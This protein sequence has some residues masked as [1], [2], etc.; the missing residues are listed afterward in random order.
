MAWMH[1]SPRRA[2]LLPGR[3]PLPCLQSDVAAGL[4]VGAMVIPQGMS[5]AKLAGLPQGAPPRQ[6]EATAG[7]SGA[8]AAVALPWPCRCTVV[9]HTLT[10]ALLPFTPAPSITTPA[11]PSLPPDP[12]YGLYGAFVPCIAYALLGSSRQ[13]VRCAAAPPGAACRAACRGRRWPAHLHPSP[14]GGGPCG[15]HLNYPRQRP[16][17]SV[18][19]AGGRGG[20]VGGWSVGAV[21][22]L[23]CSSGRRLLRSRG[24]PALPAAPSP[25]PLPPLRSCLPMLRTPTSRPSRS[26]SS[27]TTTLRCRWPLWRG[28]CTRAS[29]C[30]AWV[31]AAQGAPAHAAPAQRWIGCGAMS[32]GWGHGPP[33]RRGSPPLLRRPPACPPP[34]RLGHQL[35]VARPGVGLHDGRRNPHRPLPGAANKLCSTAA[36]RAAVVVALRAVRLQLRRPPGCRPPVMPLHCRVW[37]SPLKPPCLT[38]A[39]LLPLPVVHP[40]PLLLITPGQV[41]SGPED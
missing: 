9:T 35:P 33:G 25:P 10:V 21:Q 26:C 7:A 1:R 4:S 29:V 27:S 5:Y 11:S 28:A 23:G 17:R 38:A 20:W 2:P 37:R 19:G 34:R 14:V 40:P 41:H 12:E 22:L 3:P 16:G 32:S 31:R 18:P 15:R 6:A 8:A 24:L 39:C 36:A 13:L 30:C